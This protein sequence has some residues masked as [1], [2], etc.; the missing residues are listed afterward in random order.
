MNKII[1]YLFA[2]L[3]VILLLISYSPVQ[4]ALKISLPAQ[5]SA[6]VLGIISIVLVA[7]GVFIILKFGQSQVK[8]VP[9]YHGSKIVGYRRV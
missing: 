1:G 8:E 9:I 7:I 6:S 2:G 5:L 4:K 3:G